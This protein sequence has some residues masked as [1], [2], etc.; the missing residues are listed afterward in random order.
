MKTYTI[1]ITLTFLF[2]IT[3]LNAVEKGNCRFAG[4]GT[5]KEA[6][7]DLAISIATMTKPDVIFLKYT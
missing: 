1:L 2:S 6:S 7:K 5:I 4:K 3:N